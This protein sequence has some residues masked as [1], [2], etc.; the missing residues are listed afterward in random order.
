MQGFYATAEWRNLQ[1]GRRAV[2]V[3]LCQRVQDNKSG[4]GARNYESKAKFIP[5]HPD[6]LLPS[7]V[8]LMK[9][10]GRCSERSYRPF[11]R[12]SS[13]WKDFVL[14]GASHGFLTAFT[15]SFLRG[16]AIEDPLRGS[17]QVHC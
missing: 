7:V 3:F 1:P 16:D 4:E 12:G 6:G 17:H 9:S 14:V 5:E 15:A 10:D 8:L 13:R 11:W 2:I